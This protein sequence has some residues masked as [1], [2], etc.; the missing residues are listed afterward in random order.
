MNEPGRNAAFNPF[1]LNRRAFLADYCGG[2][3]GLALAHLLQREALA[4][5]GQRKAPLASIP[6]HNPGRAKSV[7][8]LFQH[9]GPSQMDLFDAKPQLSRH[10]GEP[11]PGKVEVHFAHASTNLLGSPFKF[12]KR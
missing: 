8:C 2:I 4:A 5:G 10:S 1:A 11:Y 12:K 9:G 6:P 3:G 7:I